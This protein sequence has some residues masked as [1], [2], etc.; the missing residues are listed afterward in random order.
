MPTLQHVTKA[1][2]VSDCKIAELTSDPS[3]GSASYATSVD[4]PGIQTL[5][6]FAGAVEV[7]YL[8][9]DNTLLDAD[10][11]LSGPITG[12]LQAAKLS[13]DVIPVILGGTTINAGTT[14]NQTVTYDQLGGAT[15]T[16]PNYFKIEATPA[17]IDLLSTT[18]PDLHVIF[19]KCKVV[20]Y[21][22]LGAIGEDYRVF[23]IDVVC[24][25]RLSDGKWWEL[26]IHE[27]AAAIT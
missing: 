12:K 20:G 2:G 3:G 10:A 8:K 5:G 7:K 23:D 1:F 15:P 25:P 22:F 26:L 27:T 24:V 16:I 17:S 11:V 6:P 19:W 21:T 9:G 4:V 13:L 14:P 18:N